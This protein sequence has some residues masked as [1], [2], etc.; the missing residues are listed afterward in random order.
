MGMYDSIY[1]KLKCPYCKEWETDFSKVYFNRNKMRH[2]ACHARHK[3]EW[4][5]KR[6][7]IDKFLLYI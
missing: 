3:R 1:L 2:K 6:R 5:R 7:I 4:K